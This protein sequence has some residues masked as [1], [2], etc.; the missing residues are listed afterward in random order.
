MKPRC[1]EVWLVDFGEPVGRRQAGRRP[2]LICS[3]DGLAD[4]LNEGVAGL[5]IVVPITTARRSLPSDIEIEPG[6]SGLDDVSYAK[7]ED[8][9]SISDRRLVT[10]LG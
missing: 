1:G 3:A 7:C 5:V 10:R 9:R 6:E 2:A 8:I 4:G